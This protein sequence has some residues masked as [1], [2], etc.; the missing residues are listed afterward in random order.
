MTDDHFWKILGVV[1]IVSLWH[2]FKYKLGY[3][4]GPSETGWRRAVKIVGIPIG[5]I[6]CLMVVGTL[7]H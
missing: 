3:R 2:A 1:A 7:I 6:V 5:I 4:D